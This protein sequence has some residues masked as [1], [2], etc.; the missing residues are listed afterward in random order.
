M[1]KNGTKG[2]LLKASKHGIL[3]NEQLYISGEFI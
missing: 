3:Q 1:T 2:D